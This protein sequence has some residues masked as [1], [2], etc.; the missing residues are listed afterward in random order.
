MAEKYHNPKYDDEFMMGIDPNTASFPL[1]MPDGDRYYEYKR[2]LL[3]ERALYMSLLRNGRCDENTIGISRATYAYMWYQWAKTGSLLSFTPDEAIDERSMKGVYEWRRRNR[4]MAKVL[5]HQSASDEVKRKWQD[6][7][8]ATDKLLQYFNAGTPEGLK[9]VQEIIR[10]VDGT[11]YMPSP[12]AITGQVFKCLA[13]NYESLTAIEPFDKAFEKQ[14]DSLRVK[15]YFDD[16][17]TYMIMRTH[18]FFLADQPS[19]YADLIKDGMEFVVSMIPYLGNAVAVGEI[20]SGRELF[21][22]SLSNRE[23]LVMLAFLILPFIGKLA[24]FGKSLYSTSRLML[25]YGGEARIWESAMQRSIK[26]S[27]NI[28]DLAKVASIEKE[29]FQASKLPGARSETLIKL[30][31]DAADGFIEIMR[32]KLVPRAMNPLMRNFWSTLQAKYPAIMGK[33]DEFAIERLGNIVLGSKYPVG[34]I[35]GK[36]LEELIESRIVPWLNRVGGTFAL[37]VAWAGQKL[38][39]APGHL[40]TD[41]LAGAKQTFTDGILFYEENFL[42]HIVAVFEAKSGRFFS[43]RLAQNEI[44]PVRAFEELEKFQQQR[45]LKAAKSE[46][47]AAAF[48]KRNKAAA[49]GEQILAGNLEATQAEIRAYAIKT[50]EDVAADASGQIER[51]L[52]RLTTPKRGA[53]YVELWIQGKS[54]RVAPITKETTKFFAIL[55]DDVAAISEDVLSVLKKKGFFIEGI[56]AGIVQSELETIAKEIHETVQANPELIDQ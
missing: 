1:A 16:N 21:G 51:D 35:K 55:P 25:L 4:E 33:L 39:F 44:K 53:D 23:R 11:N 13:Q 17:Q 15:K 6:K 45:L 28:T 22:R 2:E 43:G 38:K 26:A 34:E 46:L 42:V 9:K 19:P 41:L 31:I 47:G 20:S 27:A 7:K 30:Q 48:A 3:T 36:L 5:F 50:Y 24:K 14:N 52:R 12:N 32:S 49:I 10:G 56:G 29:V 8:D 37:G 18:Q 40:V 54:C